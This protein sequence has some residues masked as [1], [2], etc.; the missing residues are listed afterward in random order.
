MFT[1]STVSVNCTNTVS[2]SSSLASEAV[3]MDK[4]VQRVLSQEG[5][6]EALSDPH[7]QQLFSFLREDPLKAQR[8][9]YHLLEGN[10]II[11]CVFYRRMLASA[12]TDLRQKVQLLIDNGLLALQ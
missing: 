7:I 2:L 11:L 12:S 9:V 5:V 10:S 1:L 3:S 8:S 6:K 4:E